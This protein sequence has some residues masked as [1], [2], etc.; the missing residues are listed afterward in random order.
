MKGL[1]IMKSELCNTLDF[2]VS[3]Q[4]FTPADSEVPWTA[5]MHRE[6]EIVRLL[7]G[8]MTVKLYDE[9]IRLKRGDVFFICDTALHQ[10]LPERASFE[11]LLFDPHFLLKDNCICSK[12]IYTL[13]NFRRILPLLP[14]QITPLHQVVQGLFAGL[15]QREV[16]YELLCKSLLY[17]FFYL[18]YQHGIYLDKPV[19]FHK[20]DEVFEKFKKVLEVIETKYMQGI[21]LEELAG[22]A[23]FTPKYFCKFFRFMT[24]YS[25]IDFLNQYRIE[26]ACEYLLGSDYHISDIAGLCGFN[27]ISYFI[28]TFRK[29]NQM[30]PRQWQREWMRNK[31][32]GHVPALSFRS[33][34]L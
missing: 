31:K 22:V 17:Q 32:T 23:G 7:K 9:K 15:A 1:D 33:I 21:S 6:I 3:Y 8:E 11:Q 10:L 24:G 20:K 25:P 5:E 34:K 26:I 14:L 12:Q 27:D 2:P 19:V 13:L 16:G 29:Y 4:V 30:A 28:K 18:I